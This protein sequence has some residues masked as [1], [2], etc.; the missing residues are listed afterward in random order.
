MAGIGLAVPVMLPLEIAAIVCGCMGACMKLVRRKLMPKAQKHHEIKT[1]GENKLNSD[2]ILI[3]RA[4]NDGQISEQEFKIVLDELERYYND[5]KDI[6]HNKQSG[7]SE[8][9]KKVNTRRKIP[10]TGAMKKL[11]LSENLAIAPL[12]CFSKALQYIRSNN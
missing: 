5:L 12:H 8:Q 4:L 10:S 6:T 1:L 3:I 9:E 7:L 11:E 2:K